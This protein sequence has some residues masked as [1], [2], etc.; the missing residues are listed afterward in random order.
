MFVLQIHSLQQLKSMKLRLQISVQFPC[1]DIQNIQTPI[2]H[3]FSKPVFC[4]RTSWAGYPELHASAYQFICITLYF[5]L[6]AL[7][8]GVISPHNSF[9]SIPY[10]TCLSSHFKSQHRHFLQRDFPAS[11]FSRYSLLRLEDIPVL[12][13]LLLFIFFEENQPCLI[14]IVIYS[15]FQLSS[16]LALNVA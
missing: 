10:L 9:F 5:T 6:L 13:N 4:I 11:F 15:P 2:P 14:K 3:Y 16:F 8:Y 12:F 1:H 7:G